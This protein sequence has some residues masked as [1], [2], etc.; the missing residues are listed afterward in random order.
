MKG[1][2]WKVLFDV[3]G[4]LWDTQI[5]HARAEAALMKECEVIIAPEELTE[6]FAGWPTEL[7][8]QEVL[9]YDLSL[10]R[11]LAVRKWEE[12][13][14]MAEFARR[15]CD[16]RGVLIALKDKGI[17]YALG[18]ASPQRWALSLIREHHLTDL[19]PERSVIGGDMVANGK[20]APDIWLMAAGDT[21]AEHCLVVEDGLAGIEAAIKVGMPRALLLPRTHE[22][23][24][25]I[26]SP[27]DILALI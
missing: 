11:G 6:R 27:R 23:A 5:Y 2:I 18:T 22:Q 1:K 8:F 4:T 26:T 17:A 9:Q 25:Q 13:F 7:V 12:I 10:A 14:P 16:I 15:L 19:I 24:V 20:P 21:P 3:D